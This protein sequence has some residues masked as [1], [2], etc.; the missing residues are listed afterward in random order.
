MGLF[1]QLY[2]LA[3]TAVVDLSISQKR[4]TLFETH[5]GHARLRE[6]FFQA[7]CQA[8]EFQGAQLR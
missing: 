6:L 7:G 1:E 8:I 5:R 2:Q 4:Q 3:I